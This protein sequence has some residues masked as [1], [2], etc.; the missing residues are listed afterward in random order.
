MISKRAGI[1]L[2]I[3]AALIVVLAV[4]LAP[5]VPQ[6][7]SYHHFADQR[8]WLGVPRFGDVIS[9]LPFAGIGLW[10]L[11]FLAGRESHRAF[12]DLRE[13]YPYFLVFFG[14]LLTA[15]GSAYY[16][17]APNNARLVWD[18]LPMTVVFMTLV[19]AM[20]AERVSVVL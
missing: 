12:T 9:N 17:L 8:P 13:R 6:P 10:G 5:R 19:A 14:L 3:V 15:L 11:A 16:L 1:S 4:L 2:L 18:R 7:D 20:I